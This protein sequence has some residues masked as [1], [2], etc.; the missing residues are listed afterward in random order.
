MQALK[1]PKFGSQLPGDT[2]MEEAYAPITSISN[3]SDADEDEL[4]DDLIGNAR[5]KDE[6]LLSIAAGDRICQRTVWSMLS[7]RSEDVS[8]L[9]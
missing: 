4:K 1:A 5:T 2:T 3:D 6:S 9:C 8:L 7:C